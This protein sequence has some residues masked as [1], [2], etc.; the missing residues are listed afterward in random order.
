MLP[1]ICGDQHFILVHPIEATLARTRTASCIGSSVLRTRMAFHSSPDDLV[2]PTCIHMSDVKCRLS[3]AN[4]SASAMPFQQTVAQ[5]RP[6]WGLNFLMRS[7][8][9][10]CQPEGSEGTKP[11]HL[12]QMYNWIGTMTDLGC[13]LI[14]YL[15][16]S[17]EKKKKLVSRRE[18]IQ[19]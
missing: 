11:R 1:V 10:A 9:Y 14:T 4:R 3:D 8:L 15:H 7:I 18:T 2:P 13:Y 19:C 6:R 17:L 16:K 5:L 12:G